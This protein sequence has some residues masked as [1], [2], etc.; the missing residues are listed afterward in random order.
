M[1]WVGLFVLACL[2]GG[3]GWGIA[4][5]EILWHHVIDRR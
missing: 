2:V 5:G 1:D 4:L 3:L